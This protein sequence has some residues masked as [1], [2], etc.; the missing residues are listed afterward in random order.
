MERVIRD[1]IMSFVRESPDNRFP[2]SGQPYFEEPLIGFAAADDPLFDEFRTII[3]PFHLTP[4]E[5]MEN[6]YGEGVGEARTVI[7]WIL[8]VARPTRESNR[9]EERMP[10]RQWAMTRA[11]GERFNTLLRMRLVEL[12]RFAGAQ[13]A[14]PLLSGM[15]RPVMDSRIGMASTWSERHAAYVAGLGTFSLSD[16]FI[17]DRGIAHRCGSVITSVPVQPTA[18][19]CNDP[20]S[21]CLFFRDGSCCQCVRRCP[22]GAISRE[23]HDKEKCRAY[24][25]GEVRNSAIELYGVTEAGCGLCQTRV[26]CESRVPA[27]PERPG[28]A[29]PVTQGIRP[30]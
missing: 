1:G 12:L 7:C 5:V 9:K 25:Y 27:A 13:A 24:C 17:T 3:G 29:S 18:R 14:A 16:G 23:G 8:P 6:C 22:V 19:T 30:F 2:D 15:W 26:P 4:A 28:G 20:W 21:N 11:H 10:S